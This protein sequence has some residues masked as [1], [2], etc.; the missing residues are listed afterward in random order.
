MKTG[1]EL[2]AALSSVAGAASVTAQRE[3]Y[4][5]LGR[6][7]FEEAEAAK[8]RATSYLES[9]MDHYQAAVRVVY[10]QQSHIKKP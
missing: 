8:L 1:P 2:L 10:C 9:A 7:D 5:A 4:A 6:A 3:F